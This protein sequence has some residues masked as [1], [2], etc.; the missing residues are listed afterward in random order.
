MHNQV[1]QGMQSKS[2]DKLSFYCYI[3]D[4]YTCKKPTEIYNNHV[5]HKPTPLPFHAH[6]DE[7]MIMVSTVV[8]QV[9]SLYPQRWFL[10]PHHTLIKMANIGTCTFMGI[11]LHTARLYHYIQ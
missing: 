10:C 6:K 8:W 9:V 2:Q 1:S 3:S 7:S 11:K 5:T 4:I